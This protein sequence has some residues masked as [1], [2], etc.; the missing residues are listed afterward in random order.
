MLPLR[1]RIAKAAG[2]KFSFG[3]K[4]WLRLRYH[5]VDFQDD[6]PY[7]YDTSGKIS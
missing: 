2:A 4:W 3:S 6:A 7:L 1:F 5:L